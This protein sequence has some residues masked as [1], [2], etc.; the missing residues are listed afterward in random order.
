M[1]AAFKKEAWWLCECDR[2]LVEEGAK[3]R[4]KSASKAGLEVPERSQLIS[5]CKSLGMT[6]VDRSRVL[7]APGAG[8]DATDSADDFIN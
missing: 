6:P 3:L 7:V 8:A 4:A 1:W 5:I 2:V